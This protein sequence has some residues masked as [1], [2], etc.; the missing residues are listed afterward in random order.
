MI[1]DIYSHFVADAQIAIVIG[2]VA[3]GLCEGWG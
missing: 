2:V 3:H 1:W